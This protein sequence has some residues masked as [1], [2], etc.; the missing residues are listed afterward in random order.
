MKGH[1]KSLDIASERIG[2]DILMI[3]TYL[4]SREDSIVEYDSWPDTC[5]KVLY[6]MVIMV[7]HSNSWGFIL[8]GDQ[9]ETT[10]TETLRT[11]YEENY[12]W[13]FLGRR[14]RRGKW[15]WWWQWWWHDWQE[16]DWEE[17]P[18]RCKCRLRDSVTKCCLPLRVSPFI[19]ALASHFW[20]PLPPV[21]AEHC[22]KQFQDL[23]IQRKTNNSGDDPWKSFS[24]LVENPW[25]AP[26][27]EGTWTFLESSGVKGFWKFFYFLKMNVFL[28]RSQDSKEL[29]KQFYKIPEIPGRF[30]EVS[31]DS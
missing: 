16:E 17:E 4:R 29:P 25:K 24:F 19:Q 5:F 10:E 1:K 14:W 30:W 21:F 13:L 31:E 28:C 12:W 9:W 18:H 20:P 2:N 27:P 26:R 6:F 23:D 15:R 11:G 8:H 3:W 7:N 22:Q